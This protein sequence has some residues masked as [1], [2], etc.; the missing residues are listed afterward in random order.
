MIR[1]FL[2]SAL[3]TLGLTCG[4]LPSAAWADDPQCEQGQAC[5]G[6]DGLCVRTPAVG[7]VSDHQVCVVVM[8]SQPGDKR[9]F[10]YCV[11]YLT[12]PPASFTETTAAIFC[13]PLLTD[14]LFEL[15]QQC[16]SYLPQTSGSVREGGYLA[17]H[18][19]GYNP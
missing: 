2:F 11:E 13:S 14:P 3:L 15:Y 19:A 7:G 8:G 4:A 9:L 12:M 18:T 6:R 16:A 5:E 1:T 17:C 10:D